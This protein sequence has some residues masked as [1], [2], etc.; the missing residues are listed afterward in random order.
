MLFAFSS[1][2]LHGVLKVGEVVET[3][4]DASG[5]HR[6]TVYG[7]QPLYPTLIDELHCKLLVAQQGGQI[8]KKAIC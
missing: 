2:P 6:G 7:Q 8:L 3:H 5:G 1:H 4:G